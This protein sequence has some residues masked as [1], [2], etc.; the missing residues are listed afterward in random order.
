MDV[1]LPKALLVLVGT[2]SVSIDLPESFP[3]AVFF[4]GVL[5]RTCL[6]SVVQVLEASVPHLKPSLFA[7]LKSS[8]LIEVRI[9]LVEANHCIDILLLTRSSVHLNRR[10]V[11]QGGYVGIG[12]L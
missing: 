9:V 10:A 1:V 6:A 2:K 8:E 12:P 4:T 5:Y 3:V 7:A 11:A